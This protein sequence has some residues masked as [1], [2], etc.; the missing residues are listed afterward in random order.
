MVAIGYFV[1]E[2]EIE[3]VLVESKVCGRGTAY[4][5]M[6]G[7]G[8]QAMIRLNWRAFEKWLLDEGS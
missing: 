5:V 8:S 4:K 7:N 2:S 6:S 1:K 3:D